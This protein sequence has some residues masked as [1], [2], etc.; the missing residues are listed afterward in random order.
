MGEIK[1][2]GQIPSLSKACKIE[3][4]K[5]EM[6]NSL[7]LLT[8]ATHWA[9]IWVESKTMPSLQI[10]ESFTLVKFFTKYKISSLKV[11]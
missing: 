9:E 10:K 2:L 1:K 3:E 7:I 6:R 11:S 8:R 5:F 4:D